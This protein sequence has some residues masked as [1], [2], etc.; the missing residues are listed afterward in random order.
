MAHDIQLQVGNYV[1]RDLKMLNSFDTWHG[2]VEI[3]F[4]PVVVMI[5]QGPRV[6]VNL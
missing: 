1:E 6:W 3:L 5:N 4:L 2:N